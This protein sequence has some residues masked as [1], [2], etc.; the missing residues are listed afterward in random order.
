MSEPQLPSQSKLTTVLVDNLHCPSC[1]ATVKETL[2]ALRPAPFCV[3]TSIVLHE[4][5]V[6][7]PITLS[8]SRIAR[9]LEDVGFILDSVAPSTSPDL[10]AEGQGYTP[11][12][13]SRRD[14]G[15]YDA[16]DQF[17][18]HIRQ[19]DACLE[20]LNFLSRTEKESQA[21]PS[22][23]TLTSVM[24]DRLVDTKYR[25]SLALSGI[26]CSSCVGKITTALSGRPWIVSLDVNLMTSSAVV[27]LLDQA[28]VDEVLETIRESGYEAEVVDIEDAS[29]QR[30]LKR[31]ESMADTWRAS[32]VIEGMSCSSCVGKVTDTLNQH[33][34]IT[35]VDVNLV[36][37]S[38]TVEFQGKDHL[39]D[40]A[41]IID[42]L[43][44]TATLS[45]VES[46][47]PFSQ[48]TSEREIQL[49]ID[50]MHC[51][52]CPQRV[53]DALASAY[54]DEVKVLQLP[55]NGNPQVKVGYLPEIPNRTIRHIM[56][57]ISDVDPAFTVSVY[58]PPS[59]E[60]RSHAMHRRNQWQIARRLTL[61]VV[62]AIPTF[63]IG[64]V[65]MSLVPHDDPGKKYLMEHMWAGQ[66]TRTEWA[67]FI[68]A[69][70]VYF[71]SAGLFHSKTTH[72]I[73]SLW[74]PGSRTPIFR[75]FIR[76][77]SMDMLICLGTTIA[78][79]SSIAIL[80]IKATQPTDA[81]T[82][83]TESFFDSVVFLTMFLLI[84]RLLE[85]YSKAKAGDAVSLLGKLRPKEAILVNQD[86]GDQAEAS[87]TIPIDQLEF[88]DVVRVAKGASPPY[89]GTIVN[90]A[91]RFDES[92][93]T[94][95]S[96][97]VEKSVGDE[98]FSGTV[99]QADPVQVKVTRL[100]GDSML[101]QVIG[102]VRE[103]QSRRAPMERMADLL[104]GYFVPV[105][106]LIGVLDWIIWLALGLSGR[107]PESWQDTP[108]G[109]E[110]WSLQFAISVFVVACPCGIGLAAPTALFVGG[111]L[112]AQH[113]I[114]VKGGGEAFQEASQLDCV[115]FDKT[116][117]I[118]EGGEPSITN[119][120]VVH[121]GNNLGDVWGAVLELEQNSNHPI[122]SAMVSFAADQKPSAMKSITVNE[123]PGKGLKG[124]F[125]PVNPDSTSSIEMIIGNEA[126]M[127][128][129]NV[130]I[131]SAH[132]DTLM[133]W[134]R[135]AK[136]VVLVS[137]RTQA[138]AAPDDSVPWQLS[139]MLAVSDPVRPEALRVLQS[140]RDRGV[141]VW[142]ISGDNPTTAKAVG[143]IVGIPPDNII[144]GVLPEQKAEKVV[145]LQKT[146]QKPT[147]SG[148]FGGKK[149]R[150]SKRAIVAMVGDGI[151]DSPALTAADVGIAIGS[152][153]DIAISAAEFVL[154]SSGLTSLLTLVDLSR[155]VFRRIKFNFGWA[156]VYNC[157]AVPVAAGVFYP[158]V[159][160]GKHVR[161][162]PV[163]ASL[164]MALSSVSVVC[165]SLLMRTRLPLAGFRVKK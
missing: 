64:I 144:A 123:I 82:H 106:V 138:S 74:R 107:L 37:A 61:A 71:Y 12:S 57:T 132:L 150:S 73:Y 9:A 85:A 48:P 15:A 115:V 105:V 68:L 49:Q 94:G 78:F 156:L 93:L 160:N 140:L 26:S 4:I 70:P 92:S 13:N 31:S 98:V 143:K 153:S 100:S 59:L 80:A 88:G 104:T 147:Q 43:G 133:T 63:I 40:I 69:T 111:G 126:L 157:I 60:E 62:I 119:H 22:S 114:L 90:G 5:K 10:E 101:D 109:W 130:G 165:S 81:K 77:G 159:S 158:I 33:K 135:E 112:A 18:K 141:D 122:A 1:V 128:D 66:T 67:L 84:G 164:A 29:P 99:N 75:R 2:S 38:A 34:W 46:R 39:E 124:L 3:S 79:F 89:D 6:V 113:G 45:D 27:V 42:E 120:E 53:V 83:H 103:G 11:R 102:A 96:R 139:I 7:H 17:E 28:H 14:G 72:E 21:S 151:N 51:D 16:H 20:K 36:A 91:S 142:M 25:V 110:F 134:K 149:E 154:V 145:Y 125:T 127:R 152:G 148:W 8:A 76:F 118:T 97:P 95:E 30:A 23:E 129:H 116:G 47:D 19:C 131:T 117:T 87:R 137:I 41:N 55:T 121:E 155:V 54:G 162:D 44:Y 136:S 163:W 52:K 50:G 35:K 86:H 58:H 108:G 32:Y 146:L 24:D 56:R 161:L 65:Y